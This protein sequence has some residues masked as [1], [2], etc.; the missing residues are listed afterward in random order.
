MNVIWHYDSVDDV[1]FAKLI[2][3]IIRFSTKRETGFFK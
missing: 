3:T 1:F 2:E